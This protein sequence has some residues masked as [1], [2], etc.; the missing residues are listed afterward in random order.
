MTWTHAVPPPD[1]T[2]ILGYGTKRI[3]DPKASQCVSLT[4]F[5]VGFWMMDAHGGAPG[6][7][8]ERPQHFAPSWQ[9]IPQSVT[10]DISDGHGNPLKGMRVELRRPAGELIANQYL[11]YCS[12]LLAVTSK[13]A[14]LHIQA[15]SDPVVADSVNGIQALTLGLSGKIWQKF[16]IVDLVGSD[17]RK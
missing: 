7:F 17:T 12:E 1:G 16:M 5:T 8:L 15:F 11:D 2:A 4:N 10:F 3:A 6:L 14:A 9:P 13:L